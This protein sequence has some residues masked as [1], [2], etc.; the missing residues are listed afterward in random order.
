MSLRLGFF[1]KFLENNFILSYAEDNTSR[2]LSR[3]DITDPLLLRSL[4]AIQQKSREPSF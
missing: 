1:E 2:P 4:L 3:G